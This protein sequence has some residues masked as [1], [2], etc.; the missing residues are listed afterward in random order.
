MRR[1]RSTIAPRRSNSAPF[2]DPREIPRLPAKYSIPKLGQILIRNGWVEPQVVR[3]ALNTQGAL[4]DRL[5]TCLLE[6]GAVGEDL[7]LKALSEQHGLPAAAAEDLREIPED[8]I[9]TLP[10]KVALDRKAVPFRSFGTKTHV[11]ILDPRDLEGL[12]QIAFA[13]GKRI[14]PHVATE[15]RL[16]Q[17]LARYYDGGLSPHMAQLL[18]RLDRSRNSA[19]RR[20]T[21]EAAPRNTARRLW[22]E[23]ESALFRSA[24]S[25]PPP[26]APFD[27]GATAG[28]SATAILNPPEPVPGQRPVHPPRPTA[29]ARRHTSVTLSAEE[30]AALGGDAPVERPFAV[31]ADKADDT[32]PL[33]AD[34]PALPLSIA[35]AE[36][37]L[38]SCTRPEEVADVLLGFLGQ[39]FRRVVLFRVLRDEVRG[40]RAIGDRVDAPCIEAYAATFDEPS[41]FLNLRRAGSFFLGRLAPMPAHHR[42]ARCFGDRLPEESLL[43]PVRIRG[44][45]VTV[46]YADRGADGLGAVELEPLVR[47]ASAAADAYERCIL[48]RKKD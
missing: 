46:A 33:P 43:L 37:Y 2:Y 26:L 31:E 4:G 10:A 16:I 48:R 35:G 21:T 42:L 23:P 27:R 12:D 38:E 7:L 24:S 17:A 32:R 22:E 9:A 36:A 34:A 15:P 6:T 30:R 13:L 41:A 39:R 20:R 40:W 45:L 3:R 8:V 18:D 29:A 28:E 14:Q 25:S 1:G 47:L 11:A 19:P 44:R 5:G